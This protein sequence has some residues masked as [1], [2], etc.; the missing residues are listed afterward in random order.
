MLGN[1]TMVYAF[2]NCFGDALMAFGYK[3]VNFTAVKYKGKEYTADQLGLS[4]LEGKTTSFNVSANY[5]YGTSYL[6]CWT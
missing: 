5:F 3:S 1:V 4:S 2:T 6:L